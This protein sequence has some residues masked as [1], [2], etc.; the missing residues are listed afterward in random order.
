MLRQRR[1]RPRFARC[2]RSAVPPNPDHRHSLPK[3][4]SARRMIDGAL[5]LAAR[6]PRACGDDRLSNGKPIGYFRIS[7]IHTVECDEVAA[8]VA[9]GDA[10]RHVELPRLCDCGIH[11]RVCFG[12]SQRHDMLGQ[13]VSE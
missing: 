3:D 13:R 11:D 7:P 10:H 8:F 12:Q 4:A 1:R 9:Y 5:D 6:E 2:G